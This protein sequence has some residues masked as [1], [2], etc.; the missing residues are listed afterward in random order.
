MNPNY[1]HTTAEMDQALQT[2]AI[3]K[4]LRDA[5]LSSFVDMD[6]C[7]N[8]MGIGLACGQHLVIFGKPGT[9]KT[10]L[11]NYIARA[12]GQKFFYYP[13]GVE[14]S[15]DDLF[16]PI[17]P[18]TMHQVW[19]RVPAGLMN[20]VIA[21]LDEVG[22][23]PKEVQNA[24]LSAME[25]RLAAVGDNTWPIPL[26]MMIG[27]SNETIDENPAFFD[28]F[29][30]RVLVEYTND[31][32]LFMRMLTTNVDNPPTMP[33]STA[34]LANLRYVT[35]C[36]ALNPHANALKTMG[37][38]WTTYQ[39]KFKDERPVSHRRWRRTLHCAAGNALLRGSDEVQ[40]SDLSVGRFTL[41]Q[42][43]YN[44]D[45]I[46]KWVSSLTDKEL[47]AFTEASKL[48][49]EAEAKFASF[50]PT[51]TDKA[52]ADLHYDVSKFMGR[53]RNYKGRQWDDLRNRA[54][55]LLKQL[56]TVADPF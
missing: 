42:S 40:T 37:E 17:N 35:Q 30:L 11:G 48:M 38:L 47:Q 21:Y 8:A 32:K 45:E 20:A 19:E 22:K 56:V 3:I 51:V 14:T 7:I 12:I 27:A 41:W 16:G 4:Q 18:L 36:M 54:E 29:T 43:I 2:A 44:A 31:V 24:V 28:R 46:G 50:P 49:Q 13:M 53:L 10:K 34:D 9:G 33:V 1:T 23:A 5:A 55:A 26:H 15:L 52:K 6:E 25:E 39:T